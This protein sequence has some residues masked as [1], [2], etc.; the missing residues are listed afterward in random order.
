MIYLYQNTSQGFSLPACTGDVQYPGR[1][2]PNPDQLPTQ[3]QC[4]TTTD[5][6]TASSYVTVAGRKFAAPYCLLGVPPVYYA[7]IGSADTLNPFIIVSLNMKGATANPTATRDVLQLDFLDSTKYDTSG[8]VL[9]RAV[10]SSGGT[11]TLEFDTP[12]QCAAKVPIANNDTVWVVMPRNAGALTLAGQ[13]FRS[14][15]QSQADVA[16]SFSGA[17]VVL[18]ED[19]APDTRLVAQWTVQALPT[20]A[21]FFLLTVGNRYGAD[22]IARTV[23]VTV[24]YGTGI[25]E[26]KYTVVPGDSLKKVVVGAQ[27]VRVGVPGL[28]DAT[29]TV[30]AGAAPGLRV[31]PFVVNVTASTRNSLSMDVLPGVPFTVT[32]TKKPDAVHT[33]A[34]DIFFRVATNAT[35]GASG[36]CDASGAEMAQGKVLPGGSVTTYIP[37]GSCIAFRVGDSVTWSKYAPVSVTPTDSAPAPIPATV[38]SYIQVVRPPPTTSGAKGLISGNTSPAAA[39]RVPGPGDGPSPSPDPGPNPSPN[40]GP[41]DGGSGTSPGSPSSGPA[42]GPASG[43]AKPLSPAV[44]GAIVAAVVVVLVVVVVVVLKVKNLI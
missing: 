43:S 25:A 5:S 38:P 7:L 8:F 26:D 14:P 24:N 29:T 13:T 6:L 1:A 30:A 16:T 33:P 37:T 40:P 28:T 36:G 11:A 44:I 39:R 35:S 2:A 22:T 4:F 21:A 19:T 12:Y 3:V 42:Q 23:E 10:N 32:N 15:F 9:V 41:G 18:N 27:R 31:G 17:A 20:G 34:E